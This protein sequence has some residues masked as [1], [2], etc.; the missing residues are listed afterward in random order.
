MTDVLDRARTF[1]SGTMRPGAQNWEQERR[2]PREAFAAAAKAGLGG[3]L[4]PSA[5]GGAGLTLA[6]LADVMSVLSAADLGFAF[7][8]VCHNLSLIHI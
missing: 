2:F 5:Q 8:L 3:L 6:G 4:V 1:A 7:S